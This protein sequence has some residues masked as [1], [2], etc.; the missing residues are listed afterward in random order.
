MLSGAATP[1]FFREQ[2]AMSLPQ[3]AFLA[4][5]GFS[6]PLRAKSVA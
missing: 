1:S 2:A 6:L 3:L 4:F 5:L